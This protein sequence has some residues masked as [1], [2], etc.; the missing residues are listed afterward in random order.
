VLEVADGG[1][2]VSY[3]KRL[4]RYMVMAVAVLGGLALIFHEQG[5]RIAFGLLALAGVFI[6]AISR[7]VRSRFTAALQ[8]AA[9][10]TGMTMIPTKDH[11]LHQRLRKDIRW[12]WDTDT[13]EWKFEGSFPYLAGLYRGFLCTV[14]VPSGVDFDWKGPESTRLAVHHK[15]KPTGF[16]IYA[17]AGV[18]QLP[19]HR[20]VTATGD[21]AFDA[22]YVVLGLDQG[23]IS[24]VLG[25]KVRRGVEA[26]G[27][28]GIRGIELNPAGI[29]IYEPGKVCDVDR[30][31][32]IL[33]VLTAMS[34][35]LVAY[36]RDR[37][38]G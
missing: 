28:T 26:L 35:D 36:Q 24:A 13:R 9:E 19:P 38:T 25:E 37:T 30:L 21:A 14:R 31:V 5:G 16:I 29:S 10:R 11:L 12:R 18:K 20:K 3:E 1:G 2:S 7:H 32:Q 6:A 33:D 23:E 34:A 22:D 8:V 4:V 17:R 27:T 15:S